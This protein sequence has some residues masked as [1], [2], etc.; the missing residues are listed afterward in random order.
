MILHHSLNLRH[1]LSEMKLGCV[2]RHCND[3]PGDYRSDRLDKA[4]DSSLHAI[5]R[6]CQDTMNISL[7]RKVFNESNYAIY[8]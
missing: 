7:K 2:D 6:Q 1:S 3:P 4:V 5:V 8:I